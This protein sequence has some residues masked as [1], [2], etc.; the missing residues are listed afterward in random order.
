MMNLMITMMLQREKQQIDQSK[1]T[2]AGSYEKLNDMKVV[3]I[4]GDFNFIHTAS[5]SVSPH[6]NRLTTLTDQ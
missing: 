6:N 5:A 3:F 2:I 1:D 4:C